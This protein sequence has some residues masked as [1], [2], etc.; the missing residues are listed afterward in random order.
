LITKFSPVPRYAFRGLTDVPPDLLG[1]LGV[2]FLMLDLDNTVAAYNERSPSDGVARWV[3][4]AKGC[5]ISLLIVSNSL[6]K[7]RVETF[8]QALGVDIVTDAR[9]PSPKG[10]LRAMGSAGF[11]ASES[12]LIGDQA[13]TDALAA[14]RAG[15]L[16]IV[17]RPRRFTNPFLAVRYALEV[18]FRAMCRNKVFGAC[19]GG[20]A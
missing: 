6:R 3:A 19:P 14:N 13:F 5:G 15:V 12:A 1:R 20:E 9:K 2:R 10:I 8:G 17:V 4:Q 18:P 16:S 7:E 11:P